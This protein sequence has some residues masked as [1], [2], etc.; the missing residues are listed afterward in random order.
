MENSNIIQH[1]HGTTIING[2]DPLE[3]C[4]K[5][6]DDAKLVQEQLNEHK[7]KYEPL[8]SFDCGFKLDYDGPIISIGS[9]FYPPKTHYGETWDGKVHVYLMGKEI[10]VQAFDCLTLDELKTQVETYDQSI[11]REIEAIGQK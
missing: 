10:A 1:A 7:G 8:W 9:R 4:P 6:W 3:G 5:N 2:G 11:M